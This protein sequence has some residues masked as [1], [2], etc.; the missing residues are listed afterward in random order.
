[1]NYL[2]MGWLEPGIL[3]AA[4]SWAYREAYA[5]SRVIYIHAGAARPMAARA[6]GGGMSDAFGSQLQCIERRGA[7][8]EAQ[9][10]KRLSPVSAPSTALAI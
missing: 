1:M 5:S 3:I 8:K 4:G 2:R 7:G 9:G 6:G 10:A